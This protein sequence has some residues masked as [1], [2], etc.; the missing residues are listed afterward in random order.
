MENTLLIALSRQTVMERHME[1]IANNIANASTSG[2]KGEQLMFVEFLAENTEGETVSYVQD[3]AVVRDYGEGEFVTTSSPLDVAIHGKGWFIVDTPDRQ[4]YTR[5]GHFSLNEQ[6]QMVTSGGH[7]VLSATGAPITFGPNETGIKISGDGTISSSAGVK[8]QLDIVTFEDENA[9][10][11]ASE[12]LFVTDE[13]P[14]KALD[15]KVVQGM[16]ESSNVQP[17]VEITNMIWAMRSYQA[18]QEVVK[19][20]DG[21]LR[22]AID[23]I[24]DQQA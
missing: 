24:T 5:N 6:G 14:T 17:V 7:P 4:A 13:L 2:F 21:I 1:T 16:I 11:K 12:S 3:I 10:D 23:V 9:L 8:G 19:G 22:D 18:A 15:A 20:T